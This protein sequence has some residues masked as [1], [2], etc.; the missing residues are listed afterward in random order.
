MQSKIGLLENLSAKNVDLDEQIARLQKELQG[1]VDEKGEIEKRICMLQSGHEK[2]KSEF[3]ERIKYLQSA[4]D[5]ILNSKVGL[6][7]EL[8]DSN[9][10]TN[11]LK[12]E[13]EKVK[14]Q[15]R[16]A[17]DKLQSELSHTKTELV[18]NSF[19]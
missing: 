15:S 18:S 1:Q 12:Q 5:L 9:A 16:K 2:E 14:G 17:E 13:I 4:K 7:N 6:Q 19:C 3:E 10:R 8:E 11:I